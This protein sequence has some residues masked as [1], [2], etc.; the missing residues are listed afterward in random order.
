MSVVR[1]ERMGPTG[2]AS[3]D[4]KTAAKRVM[5]STISSKTTSA[6][7]IPTCGRAIVGTLSIFTTSAGRDAVAGSI[8]RP[9]SGARTAGTV[10]VVDGSTVVDG[11]RSDVEL[12]ARRGV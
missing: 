7:L 2:S 4:W 5:P 11:R 10:V 3:S 1:A 12:A 9:V 6:W 8:G